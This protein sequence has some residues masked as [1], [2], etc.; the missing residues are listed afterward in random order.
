LGVGQR[1]D[2]WQRSGRGLLDRDDGSGRSAGGFGIC[3]GHGWEVFDD[4]DLSGLGDFASGEFEDGEGI[5]LDVAVFKVIEGDEFL[6]IDALAGGDGGEGVA[7]F[8]FVFAA[9]GDIGGAGDGAFFGVLPVGGVGWGE[10]GADGGG[11]VGEG[12]VAAAEDAG[13]AGGAVC[14]VCD[15]GE[16]GFSGAD[17]AGCG[18]VFRGD[19]GGVWDA[20]GGDAGAE[21]GDVCE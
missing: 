15:S 4:S 9:G 8:D 7:G 6:D 10:A 13:G 18:D 1:N 3:C 16:G 11:S 14:G 21:S 12:V 19:V 20:G 5:Q 2:G 17:G